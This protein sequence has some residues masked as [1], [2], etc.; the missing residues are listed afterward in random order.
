MKKLTTFYASLLFLVFLGTSCQKMEEPNSKPQESEGSGE[1]IT[2]ESTL[3][4]IDTN[5]IIDTE[6]GQ[7]QTASQTRMTF[8]NLEHPV[9]NNVGV[10]FV[11]K[12]G[13]VLTAHLFFKQGSTIKHKTENFE[14]LS[15]EKG[16]YRLKNKDI[17]L[18]AGISLSNSADIY[19]TGAIGVTNGKVLSGQMRVEVPSSGKLMQVLK[20]YTVPM[21]FPLT[22]VGKP[23]THPNG[24]LYPNFKLLGAIV[25]VRIDNQHSSK[26]F[27]NEL[28]FTT[29]AFDTEGIVNL[30]N[31]LNGAAPTWTATHTA[32]VTKRKVQM[33]N[34]AKDSYVPS[35]D[36]RGVWGSK[37]FFAWV[38]P[39]N[40]RLTSTSTV[41]LAVKSFDT[42]EDAL[43]SSP[44][45]PWDDGLPELEGTVKV[46]KL[47]QSGKVHRLPVL[48]APLPGEL[49]I[50]EVF[51][52]AR[53]YNVAIEVY[54]SS[55]HD[56]NLKD[57][58]MKSFDPYKHNPPATEYSSDLLVGNNNDCKLLYN[59]N[60]GESY[61]GAVLA[62]QV[63]DADIRNNRY[64]LK[65]KELAVFIEKS[66][67]WHRGQVANP[68]Q[69]PNLAYVFNVG[70]NGYRGFHPWARGGYLELHRKL[71]RSPYSEIVDVFLKFGPGGKAHA[72]N[73]AGDAW[74]YTFMRKPDRNT[75][76]QTMDQGVNSDWVARLRTESIDW[77]N[78]FGYENH[79]QSPNRWFEGSG[80]NYGLLGSNGVGDRVLTTLS[81]DPT[82]AGFVRVFGEGSPYTYRVPS[83]WKKP[84]AH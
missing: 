58:M 10:R 65:P 61:P 53:E 22:K 27:V 37:W 18:P 72:S 63:Q 5:T 80:Q 9:G 35:K 15:H 55:D 30:T 2:F 51:R 40:V 60:T 20:N 32:G 39:T 31:T 76:R 11:Y 56:V 66:V 38:M 75:P 43:T 42:S 83:W 33:N 70:G 74:S 54:N 16:I 68:T 49:I 24:V 1:F 46:K 41:K 44:I 26:F 73:A 84:L 57:Y 36:R 67:M 52:G 79:P 62:P 29:N 14:V 17:E 77:G 71:K 4:E 13:E 82:H 8:M 25:G 50:T 78:R 48:E 3:E 21:Y 19:V 34:L 69:R 47:L 59:R 7:T 23:A 12:T 64:I 81:T 45:N 28:E 6:T